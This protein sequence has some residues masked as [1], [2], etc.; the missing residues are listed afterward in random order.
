MKRQFLLVIWLW[1]GW[2]AAVCAQSL[3]VVPNRVM[4]DEVATIRASGLQPNERVTIRGA[5]VDGEEHAWASEAE[6][7]ADAQGMVDASKQA[8]EKGSYK[9]I[10]AMGLVWSMKPVEKHVESYAGP[11]ELGAQTIQFQLI[12]KGQAI[13]STQLE[14]RWIGDGV[15]QIKV[16]GKLHGVLY[17]PAGSGRKPG[18]L[19]VGGSEGGV[20]R[21]KAAWLASHGYAALA[22]AYF[23]YEDLPQYLEAIPLE[24]FGTAIGWMR[25]RPEIDPERVAVMGTSRGGELA[26]QLG[27]MYPQIAAVVAYVPADV[28]YPSC[29]GNTDVPYAW[30]WTGKPLPYVPMRELRHPDAAVKIQASIAVER[31][32]G[33]ILVI[34]GKD[35]G[36]WESWAMAD[37]VVSRLKQAHFEPRVERY[38]YPHAGHRA[39]RPEIVPTW[40]GATRHPVSGRVMDVGGTASGDAASS[41][42]AI[43]KVLAFLRESLQ[44]ESK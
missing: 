15:R 25:E 41:M 13:A 29:C 42:D 7:V 37:A 11:R 24:Y 30:T 14:Q 18:V 4:V 38:E 26:L 33:P 3:E 19:V 43:G 20:P 39:G 32:H 16:E 34:S 27:S 28:R 10:S 21:Q 36:V 17:L 40:H 8:P 22:L 35:D 5:L 31:T 44:G 23:R 1:I 6:F 12:R 2:T 9:E